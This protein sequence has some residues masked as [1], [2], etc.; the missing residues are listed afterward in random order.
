M[1]RYSYSH[2]SDSSHYGGDQADSGYSETE[3]LIGRDQA[4]LEL[5]YPEP[6]R[7]PTQYP[8]QPEVEFGFPQVCYCGDAPILATSKNDPGRRVYTCKN[9]DDGDCHVWKFW[10]V[11]VMEEM[12][13]RD[14]HIL[15]LEEKV[16]NLTLMSNFEY[17]E[18]MVRLENLVSDLAKKSFTLKIE[19]EVCVGVMLFVLVVLGLVIGGK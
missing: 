5:K 8:P 2:P 12:R 14:K 6:S 3:E 10:D 18:K 17:E 13:V 16:D 1:G 11:A 19:F 7:Y 15:Q 4:E 9:V